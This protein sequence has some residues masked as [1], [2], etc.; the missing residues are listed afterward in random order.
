MK[1]FIKIFFI[2]LSLLV[3]LLIGLLFMY[4]YEV[5]SHSR[6]MQKEREGK[7]VRVNPE[8]TWELI[9]EDKKDEDIK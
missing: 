5:T 6:A 1:K 7:E 2:S 8:R 4:G 9:I 3:L